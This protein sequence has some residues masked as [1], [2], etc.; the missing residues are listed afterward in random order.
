MDEEINYYLNRCRNN[1]FQ[2]KLESEDKDS[3]IALIRSVTTVT[4]ERERDEN[5]VEF[6]NKIGKFRDLPEHIIEIYETDSIDSKIESKY[7][8]DQERYKELVEEAIDD[9]LV[10]NIPEEEIESI[11]AMLFKEPQ[12]ES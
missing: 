1:E 9:Y 2:K 8:I 11:R 10:G 3:K 12:N 6:F 5:I 7:Q 4:E